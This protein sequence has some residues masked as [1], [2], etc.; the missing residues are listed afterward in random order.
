M[1]PAAADETGIPMLT[2]MQIDVAAATD[3]GRHRKTNADAFLVDEAAGLFAVADAIGDTPRSGIVSRMALE[4]VRELFLAPWSQLPPGDR[5]ASEAADRLIL[6]VM[7]AN[8]RLY[9]EGRPVERRLGTTFAGAVVCRDHLC[10]GSAGDSRLYLYRASTAQMV[11]LTDDDTAQNDAIWRGTPPD[12]A[13]AQPKAHALTRAIGIR[14]ALDLRP[15]VTRWAPG[16]VVL[17]CTDGITDWLDGAA[18]TRTIVECDALELTA[19]RLVERA[20]MAGG[21]DNA[22]A[23]LVRWV[24]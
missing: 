7:Q 3:A 21:R 2:E 13:A 15:A 4:A 8:G 19:Q 16:D 20:L 14:R 5:C 23:V 10:V 18:I 6:G 12:V 22:T 11:K 9:V 17:A 24:A 1:S